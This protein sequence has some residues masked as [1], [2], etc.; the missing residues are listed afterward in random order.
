MLEESQEI[1][2]RL[3]P[4]VRE[5]LAEL[6]AWQ[7]AHPTIADSRINESQV[8]LRRASILLGLLESGND[9]ELE[10]ARANVLARMVSDYPQL[11]DKP[12]EEKGVTT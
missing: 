12:D 6:E 5:V 1:G 4:K 2:R 7:A 9:P 10:T 11:A 8:R 3:A